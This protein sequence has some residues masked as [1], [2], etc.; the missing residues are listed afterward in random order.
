MMTNIAISIKFPENRV[1]Q[2]IADFDLLKFT[3]THAQMLMHAH[4]HTQSKK[5]SYDYNAFI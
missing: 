2:H 5:Y 4:T 1:D 3:Y